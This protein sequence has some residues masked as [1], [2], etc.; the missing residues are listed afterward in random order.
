[1]PAFEIEGTVP[2]FVSLLIGWQRAVYAQTKSTGK[3]TVTVKFS[4]GLC[5]L[6]YEPIKILVHSCIGFMNLMFIGRM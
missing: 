5:K 1:M 3:C 2:S 4:S 6:S